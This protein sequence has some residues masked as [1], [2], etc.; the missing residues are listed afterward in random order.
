MI[1]TGKSR[2]KGGVN[3]RL[4]KFLAVH[5]LTTPL[6]AEEA[7][8]IAKK[9]CANC[10]LDAYW[11]GSWVQLNAD[12]NI[13]KIFCRWNGINAETIQQVLAKTPEIPTEGVYP[14]ATLDSGDFR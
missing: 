6:T 1:G 14:M 11:L 7:A 4:P 8:P 12:G 10:T 5:P 3:E 2:R 9:V 13:V